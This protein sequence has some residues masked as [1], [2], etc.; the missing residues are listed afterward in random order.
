MPHKPQKLHL[1]SSQ[2]PK[3][4]Y[5]FVP[6][7]DGLADES[8][9]ANNRC[10]E[11]NFETRAVAKTAL[12]FSEHGWTVAAYCNLLPAAGDGC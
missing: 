12:V 8:W 11:I 5:A 2:P 10:L 9:Q 6:H 3:S 4:N 1:H 7:K